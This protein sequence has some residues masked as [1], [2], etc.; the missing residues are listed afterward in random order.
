MLGGILPQMHWSPSALC[1]L[2]GTPMLLGTVLLIL[3]LQP[4]FCRAPE[5]AVAETEPVP[6]R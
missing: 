2:V 5:V 6:A 4:H 1:H 3:R